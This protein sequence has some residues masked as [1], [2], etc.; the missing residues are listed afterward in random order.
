MDYPEI[1]LHD[2]D[3]AGDT[4]N[5]QVTDTGGIV[6]ECEESDESSIIIL[7]PADSLKLARFITENV[8]EET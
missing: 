6:L 2:C 4:L 5:A 7:S 1:R 8:Q 3:F